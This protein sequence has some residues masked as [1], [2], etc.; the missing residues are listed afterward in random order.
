M[1]YRSFREFLDGVKPNQTELAARLEIS[2]SFLSD[3]K[4]GR[5]RISIDLAEKIETEIGIP[6]MILLYP[7]NRK[8]A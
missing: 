4:H 3:I 1:M 7:E 5:R 6:K 2:P 8:L